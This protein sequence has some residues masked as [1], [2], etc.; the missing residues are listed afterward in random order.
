[1]SLTPEELKALQKEVNKKKRIASE[2]A[3]QMHDLAEERLPD[4]FDEIHTIA[5]S[6]YEAC[7]AWKEAADKLQA[8]ESEAVS[9]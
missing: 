4:G 8:A 9:S 5:Q 1:M 2:W 6:T 7:V 3:G